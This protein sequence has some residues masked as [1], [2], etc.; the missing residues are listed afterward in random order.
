M[1]NPRKSRDRV[2]VIPFTGCPFKYGFL[3]NT[4]AG[5]RSALG[6]EA[7]DGTT[8][9]VVFGANAP[10][11]GRASKG[12]DSSYY[13]I[14]KRA[15]LLTAKWN[16]TPPKIRRGK[17]STKTKAVYVE[18]DGIKYAWKQPIATH[19]AISGDAAGLGVVTATGSERDLVYGASFP[20]P[21]RARKL[22]LIGDG[23]N[24]R[25]ESYST[26]ID[27]DA[28]LASLT[29]WEVVSVGMEI[30]T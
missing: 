12:S 16:L 23:A 27:D 14:G 3:T 15:T 24:Q 4:E 28:D 20:K 17:S 18:V 22:I 10:K 25:E 6:Q 9:Q 5:V 21:R 30:V 8:T 29:G 7:V 1:G 19:A 11:P 26:F 13:S 2:F